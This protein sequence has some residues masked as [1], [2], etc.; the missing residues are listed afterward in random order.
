[1]TDGEWDQ[2]IL[3]M[4][5]LVSET[6]AAFGKQYHVATQAAASSIPIA[7]APAATQHA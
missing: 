5:D 4:I 1:M 6:Y 7:A 2:I 3:A